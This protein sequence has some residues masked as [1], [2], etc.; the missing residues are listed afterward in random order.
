MIAGIRTV[1][2]SDQVEGRVLAGAFTVHPELV[3]A[4]VGRVEV[5]LLRVKDHAVDARVR[6][7][8]VVLD[9]LDQGAAGRVCG[10]NCAVTGV[11]V[12][13]VAVDGVWGFVG[14]EEEDGSGVCGGQR[15]AGCWTSVTFILN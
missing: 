11:V 10:E 3:G 1:D 15:S 13:G 9:I 6:L 5:L 12:E 14:G 2:G 7:V 8:L 4:Q